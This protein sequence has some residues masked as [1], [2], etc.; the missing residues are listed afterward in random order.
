MSPQVK[1][2]SEAIVCK[3]ISVR[4][5][6][7]AEISLRPRNLAVYGKSFIKT[8]SVTWTK[9]KIFMAFFITMRARI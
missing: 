2:L 6:N 7:N 5:T 3:G 9:V 1:E 8:M 4:T